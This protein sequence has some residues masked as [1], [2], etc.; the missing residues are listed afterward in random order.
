MQTTSALDAMVG[1]DQA[2]VLTALLQCGKIKVGTASEF[3]IGDD[4][5]SILPEL[6]C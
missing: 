1:Q 3:L 2:S 5:S 6:C 4:D